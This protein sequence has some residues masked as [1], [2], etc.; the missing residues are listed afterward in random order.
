MKRPNGGRKASAKKTRK[1]SGK[2]SQSSAAAPRPTAFV[3]RAAVGA[4]H[5]ESLAE[6]GGADGIREE[7]RLESAPAR[8]VGRAAHEPGSTVAQIAAA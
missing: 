6:H 4:L 3:S 5:R 7:G 2:A 8:C 1:R